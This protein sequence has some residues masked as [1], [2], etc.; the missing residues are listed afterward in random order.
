MYLC[1]YQLLLKYENT[2][3]MSP[4]PV[5]SIKPRIS[6]LQGIREVKHLPIE[7]AEP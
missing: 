2:V 4:Y 7:K 3:E 6:A 1:T 5:P